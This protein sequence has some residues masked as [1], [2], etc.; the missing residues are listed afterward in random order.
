[1]KAINKVKAKVKLDKEILVFLL[2]LLIVG[3]ISGT[4][5]SIILNNSDKILVSEHLNSFL[6]SIE[7]NKINFFDTF[8]NN[9]FKNVL[10]VLVIWL[11]GISLIGL[12]IV[13]VIYFSKS[14]ILGFTIGSIINIFKV[15]GILFSLIYIFPS[16]VINIIIL[17]LLTMY[18]MGFSLKMIYS[19]FK[20]KT[21]D[22]KVMINRYS[23]VLLIAL[24]INFITSLYVSYLFPI[25]LKSVIAFIR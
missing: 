10:Y 15:K 20:K 22:F 18:S 9:L 12:P 17:I 6:T 21:I 1:M 19:V 5:F 23:I 7:Q 13:V 16:E 3:I 14:F 11:L 8:M 4:I 25:I 24:V 2:V